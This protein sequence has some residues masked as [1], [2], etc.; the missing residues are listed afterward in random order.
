[1][2]TQLP[3]NKEIRVVNGIAVDSFFDT[4]NAIKG[5]PDIGNFNFRIS[6]M[7]K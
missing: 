1:M 3:E 4:I 2:T 6:D 7:L 5:D